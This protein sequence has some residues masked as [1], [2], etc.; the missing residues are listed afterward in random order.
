MSRKP[1]FFFFLERPGTPLVALEIP[2][3]VCRDSS[4]NSAS[5][6]HLEAKVAPRIV[7]ERNL[8]LSEEEGST[9]LE[10]KS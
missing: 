1:A 6:E 4:E 5:F 7:P 8:A 2:A 9:K 3:P 10:N